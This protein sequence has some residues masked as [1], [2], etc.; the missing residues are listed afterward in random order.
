M[1]AFEQQQYPKNRIQFYVYKN[2]SLGLTHIYCMY[3]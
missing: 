2:K 1:K 3:V